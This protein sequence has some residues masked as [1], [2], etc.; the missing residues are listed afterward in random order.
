MSQEQFDNA[1]DSETQGKPTIT[2]AE[3]DS[4]EPSSIGEKPTITIA[5][6]DGGS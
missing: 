6:N 5:E 4:D 1:D 2:I 3:A